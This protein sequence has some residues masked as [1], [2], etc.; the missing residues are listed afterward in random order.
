MQGGII[1]NGSLTVQ[2]GVTFQSGTVS[3]TIISTSTV[4]KTTA[5]ALTLTSANT[6]SGGVDIQAGTVIGLDAA[7]FGSGT[8]LL[9]S[10]ASV[11]FDGYAVANNVTAAG[12]N[13]L[14]GDT[15]AGVVTVSAL[16]TVNIPSANEMAGSVIVSPTGKLAIAGQHTGTINNDGEVEVDNATAT[17][18]PVNT[19]TGNCGST[20]AVRAA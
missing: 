18:P 9:A 7:A 4:T 1:Q 2:S 8:I 5:G 17:N 19:Y 15:Y 16:A 20:Y 3:A 12:G 13:L 6:F 14:G 11:D 10:G